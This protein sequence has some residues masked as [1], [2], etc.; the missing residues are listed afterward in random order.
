MS[1]GAKGSPR[2]D[3]KA[4]ANPPRSPA[5]SLLADLVRPSPPATPRPAGGSPPLA[6]LAALDLLPPDYYFG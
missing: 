4:P 5:I 1:D 6:F 2:R 3:Q